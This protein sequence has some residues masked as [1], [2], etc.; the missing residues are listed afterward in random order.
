VTVDYA[1]IS[2]GS[3]APGDDYVVDSG[4]LQFADGETTGSVPVEI[5]DDDDDE[6]DETVR[7]ELSNPT[8]GADLT[9]PET[10]FLT[11]LDDDGGPV[12]LFADDFEAGDACNWTDA[13]GLEPP[14][15]P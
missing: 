11:I 5:V 8:G 13:D 10:R 14:C 6:G 12:A 1:T 15:L 9:F 4:T 2:G 3:A 7:L